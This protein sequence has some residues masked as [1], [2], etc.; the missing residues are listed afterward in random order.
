LPPARNVR[1]DEVLARVDS[2]RGRLAVSSAS[3][4]WNN[5]GDGAAGAELGV[6]AARER[7]DATCVSWRPIMSARM[8]MTAYRKANAQM[9]SKDK[10][11]AA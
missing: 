7:A 9:S 11:V 6:E 3:R 5:S 10:F 8:T 1:F 4:A 2:R